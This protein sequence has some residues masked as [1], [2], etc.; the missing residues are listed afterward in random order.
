M[1][2]LLISIAL[3]LCLCMIPAAMAAEDDQ[4]TSENSS[5]EMEEEI[6]QMSRG[7]GIAIL[8]GMVA[9]TAFGY[10]FISRQ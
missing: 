3:V 9:S 10:Y 2:K 8:I 5:L 4:N 1:K 7:M 6:P